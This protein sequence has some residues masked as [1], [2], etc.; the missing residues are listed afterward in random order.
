MAA[1]LSASNSVSSD[2]SHC[3]LGICVERVDERE[4]RESMDCCRFENR[5]AGDKNG[6]STCAWNCR[7]GIWR[8]FLGGAHRRGG[9]PTL[10]RCRRHYNDLKE[11]RG[12]S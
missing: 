9:C 2:T 4:R 1:D 11:L 6:D 7:P 3:N 8:L 10:F 12:S 5:L